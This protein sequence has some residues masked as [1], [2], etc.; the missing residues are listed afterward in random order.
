MPEFL[1]DYVPGVGDFFTYD[2]SGSMVYLVTALGD[3]S[4]GYRRVAHARSDGTT[5]T[6]TTWDLTYPPAI[7]RLTDGELRNIPHALWVERANVLGIDPPEREPLPAPQNTHPVYRVGDY[8]RVRGSNRVYL[9]E[10]IHPTRTVDMRY[11]DS[12]GEVRR[13][14]RW[15]GFSDPGGVEP[16]TDTPPA[17]L[18]AWRER[19]IHTIPDRTIT[20]AAPVS[21]EDFPEHVRQY[22]IAG[23]IP[24][25]SLCGTRVT[26]DTAATHFQWCEGHGMHCDH[27]ECPECCSE[28]M[29]TCDNCGEDYDPENGV[30]T[31]YCDEHD[32]EWCWNQESHCADCVRDERMGVFNYSYKPAPVWFGGVGAPFYL[33][34]ELEISADHDARPVYEW[35]EENGHADMLYCKEDGSVSGFEI[36]SHPMTQDYFNSVDWR[37]FF[38]MLNQRYPRPIAN[39]RNAEPTG[40]GLHVHISRTA[41]GKVNNGAATAFFSYLINK[42]A[43]EVKKLARRDSTWGRYTEVPVSSVL[44]MRPTYPVHRWALGG[45]SAPSGRAARSGEYERYHA[46]NLLNPATL[47]VRVFRSTRNFRTLMR[48]VNFVAD[49][50][51]YAAT[52]QRRHIPLADALLWDTYA[53][54]AATREEARNGGQTAL[55]PEPAPEPVAAVREQRATT[56]DDLTWRAMQAFADIPRTFAD[57]P[58][59]IMQP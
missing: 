25:C 47:E 21:L 31:G 55:M 1:S 24:A 19:H 15:E 26:P 23:H 3:E 44:R 4:P 30:H 7:R 51:V 12:W 57:I 40:H 16:F 53:A 42:N 54:F 28:R 41:F 13:V 32:R 27:S 33:G 14:N 48:C 35:C 9:L 10:R 38:R 45:R 2:T 8:F 22:V 6:G 37:S 43:D 18:A 52:M 50:A 17:D 39:G 58:R 36:V 29:T 11:V 5:T 34:F 59:I 46:V 56:L 20:A 49:A